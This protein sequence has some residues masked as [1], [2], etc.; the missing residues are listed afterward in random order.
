VINT[1]VF[2]VNLL[3]GN[4][5][6]VADNTGIEKGHYRIGAQKGKYRKDR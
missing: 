3:M 4:R 2:A 1:A 5:R 6:K